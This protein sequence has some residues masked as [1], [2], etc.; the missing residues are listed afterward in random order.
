MLKKLAIILILFLLVVAGLQMFGGR[1]FRQVSVAWDKYQH[2]GTLTI[3]AGDVVTI[4]AGDK[5]NEGDLALAKMADRLIYR[6]TD[7]LGVV[8]NSER[9]PSV[10]NYEVIR[11]GDLKLET[12][13]S[14]DKEEIERALG[15]DQ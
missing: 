12:Q 9:M 5:V 10:K 6:W 2:G 8:H 11:M 13:K 1:D 3:L 15:E 14:L 4:F 7:E